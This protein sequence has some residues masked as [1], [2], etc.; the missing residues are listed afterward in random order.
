MVTAIIVFGALV[1]V[2]GV[3]IIIN[4]ELIFG[5]LKQNIQ[6]TSL[7][8]TAVV[9]RLLLGV[10]LIS[11]ADVSR[12]PLVV[13]VLGWLSIVAALVFAA[14]GR[15]NF[16]RLMS[17]ALSLS[18]PLGRLGGVFASGFGGFLVYAFV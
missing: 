10:L 5:F 11:S 4:P 8:I 13:E 3:I 2:A 12:F 18:Q 16:I 1:A 17:W 14:V 6:K 7:H 9:V 15:R